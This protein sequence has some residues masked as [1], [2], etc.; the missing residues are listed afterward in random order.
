[1]VCK[2]ERIW[3]T[4]LETFNRFVL[5]N[6]L[7]FISNHSKHFFKTF[8]AKNNYADNILALLTTLPQPGYQ[9]LRTMLYN[10]FISI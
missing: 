10:A 5:K 3:E 4:T 7:L 9:Y 6:K 1:M 2:K 8:L